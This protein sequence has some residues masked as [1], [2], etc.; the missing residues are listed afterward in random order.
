[1]W[2]SHGVSFRPK[3]SK[4]FLCNY[5]KEW[6]GSCPVEFK[7]KL[8]RRYVD[9]IVVMFQSRYHVKKLLGYMN[10]KHP[11]IRF[12]FQT[13]HQNSFSFLDIKI[14][15]NTE[16]IFFETSVYRKSKFSGAFTNFSSFIPI[17]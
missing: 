17:A 11:I 13:E 14:I 8:Y 6:L 3:P 4:I 2:S 15:R 1:M 16:K 12:I 7:P 5:E 9:D 10:T